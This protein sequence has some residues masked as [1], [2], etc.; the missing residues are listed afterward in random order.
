[1]KPVPNGKLQKFER[2]ALTQFSLAMIPQL[3]R[4]RVQD[5]F[6]SAPWRIL[7]RGIILIT[8]YDTL[9]KAFDGR[10]ILKYYNQ[11]TWIPS[12]ILPH[13]VILYIINYIHPSW[14]TNI[15]SVIWNSQDA[16]FFF[17]LVSIVEVLF[18]DYFELALD[19]CLRQTTGIQEVCQVMIIVRAHTRWPDEL[20]HAACT[21]FLVELLQTEN[22]LQTD[23]YRQEYSDV[24]HTCSLW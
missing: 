7:I 18:N 21:V 3:A 15:H 14:S 19:Y 10:V 20:S 23:Q 1:M 4:V 8:T 22:C 6:A 2:F 12:L 13:Y 9:R 16:F 11:V 5:S 17:F 24:Q